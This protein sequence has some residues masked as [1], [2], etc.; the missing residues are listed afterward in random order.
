MPIDYKLYPRNWKKEIVPFILARANNCCE[1]CGVPNTSMQWRGRKVV[2]IVSRLGNKRKGRKTLHYNSKQDAINDGCA[3]YDFEGYGYT[4]ERIAKENFDVY[5][6]KIVL[7]VAHLDH[8][9]LNHDVKME[10]L[11]AM[12]QLCHLQYDAYEKFCRVMGVVNKE[13]L[14]FK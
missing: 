10:R 3:W 13:R 9:E 12:C 4:P 11:M 6:T 14:L 1:K 7:T 2:S 8:D 5:Q